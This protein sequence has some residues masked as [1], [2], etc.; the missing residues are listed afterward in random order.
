MNSPTIPGVTE[1]VTDILLNLK[2]I[3]FRSPRQR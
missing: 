2:E 3:P 1:D